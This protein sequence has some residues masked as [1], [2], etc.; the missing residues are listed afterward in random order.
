ME[1]QENKNIY[2]GVQTVRTPNINDF[3]MEIKSYKNILVFA[4]VC[5]GKVCENSLELIGEANRLKAMRNND[6][7]VIAALLGFGVK[8][9][10][11]ELFGYG[12]D[13]VVVFDDQKLE[14]YR[15]DLYGEALAQI[16]KSYHPEIVLVGAT[17]LGSE[18]AP[19]VAAKLK[20]GL[21]AHCTALKILEN[22]QFTQVVPAFGGKVLGDIYI[23]NHRPQIASIK[24]GITKKLDFA[25]KDGVVED[26]TC[27]LTGFD[28]MKVVKVE[29]EHENR[30]SLNEADCIVVGGFGIGSK[31]NWA[32]LEELASLLGGA[33]GCT[34]PVLD[35]GWIDNEKAMIGTSGVAVR[36]KAYIG[37]GVSGAAHHTCGIKDSGLIISINKDEN[38]PI[39]ACSDYKVIGDYKK[40]VDAL[41]EELKA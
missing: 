21:A 25:P 5:D 6:S 38:A 31:E 13:K 19:T 17:A 11:S 24:G 1:I 2:V 3:Y 41:I 29:K 30:K 10:A 20:T 14:N 26:F 12:A 4:E 16:V 15:S 7:I 36:P 28:R 8:S 9:Y 40:I 22:G 37:I 32:K 33:N 39:F 35:A 27:E 18:L 23:P 34:R